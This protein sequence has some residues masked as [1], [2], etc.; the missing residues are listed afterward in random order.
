VR[1]HQHERAEGAARTKGRGRWSAGRLAYARTRALAIIPPAA[2]HFWFVTYEA[3]ERRL[4]LSS[5]ADTNEKRE[6]RPGRRPPE[7][8]E[9]AVQL[10]D[11]G[12]LKAELGLVAAV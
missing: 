11:V 10:L 4:L 5:P 3:E 2:L 1:A 6:L 9:D 7:P 12:V 8:L